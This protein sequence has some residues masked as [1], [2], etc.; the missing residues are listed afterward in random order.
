[1]AGLGKMVLIADRPGK[2]T[3][4]QA[5]RSRAEWLH[6]RLSNGP[7]GVSMRSRPTCNRSSRRSC[8]GAATRADRSAD[9]SRLLADV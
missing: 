3:G 7:F 5:Q 8:R 2:A 6:G 4:N 1:M 9:A